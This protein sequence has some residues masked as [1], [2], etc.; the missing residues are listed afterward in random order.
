VTSPARWAQPEDYPSAMQTRGASA[1]VDF[2]L[3]INEIG[4]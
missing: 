2:R 3:A 4:L 1:I